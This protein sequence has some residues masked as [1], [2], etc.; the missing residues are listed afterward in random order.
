MRLRLTRL[1]LL[2]G[3]AL[4]G[5]SGAGGASTEL[6]FLG[7]QIFPTAT[8]FQGTTFGGLSSMAYDERRNVFYVISDD[9]VNVR[10]YTLRIG[11]SSG[12]P[13]SRSSPSRL[14]DASGQPFASLSL[15][16]EGLALTKDDTLSSRPRASRTA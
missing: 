2:I 16:P 1:L 9:Q 15:D 12:A 14:R 13:T 8:Q 10:F 11:V 7:Q 3:I 4:G 6:E 5:R